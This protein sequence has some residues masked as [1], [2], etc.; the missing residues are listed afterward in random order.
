ML[1][2]NESI[3]RAARKSDE[4]LEP[5]EWKRSCT[6]LR[7]ER[8]SNR[9]DLADYI[10]IGR[11]TNEAK[12]RISSLNVGRVKKITE[13]EYFA[14]KDTLKAEK[15]IHKIISNVRKSG[16]W[17]DIE[18]EKARKI[19]KDE[20]EKVDKNYDPSKRH[21]GGNRMELTLITEQ[22]YLMLV[23]SFTDDL[24]W[25]V[26]RQLVKSYF[27]KTQEAFPKTIQGQIQLLA[28]GYLE[29]EQ[30]L[31]GIDKDL[32]DFK[33]DMPLLGVEC[34]KITRAKNQKVVPLMGGKEASAYKNNSLRGKVYKDINNQLCREFDVD[35]YK[36][37]KR[38]QVDTAVK[39]IENYQLPMVLQEQ[40]D[41]ANR[42]ISF[43]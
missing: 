33:K 39:I 10:K 41:L 12:R 5:Y 17:F 16:E 9:P 31:E 18:I 15:N 7:R 29:L 36:A 20:I 25:K 34:Q 24:A 2:A 19:I 14:C 28:K 42:Q 1:T 6:V 32:Q 40:I 27:R 13:Y 35:T 43:V 3:L 37:I 23:K 8:A 30:K 21:R 26:Q 22:G 38:N 11:T 4:M